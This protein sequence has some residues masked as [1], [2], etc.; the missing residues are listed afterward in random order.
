MDWGL[1]FPAFSLIILGA[2]G[3]WI[4]LGGFGVFPE[5]VGPSMFMVLIGLIFLPAGLFKDGFPTSSRAKAVVG[6]VVFIIIAELIAV[7]LGA[8]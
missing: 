1:L 2:L 8:L 7:L 4:T 3:V 5:L 6:A